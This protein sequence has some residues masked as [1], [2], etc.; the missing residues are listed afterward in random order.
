M[1][2]VASGFKLVIDARDI[3]AGAVLVQENYKKD[4]SPYLFLFEEV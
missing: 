4:W 3:G 2:L 1:C